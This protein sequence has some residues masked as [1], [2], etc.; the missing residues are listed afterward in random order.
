M[1]LSLSLFSKT[2]V[3][4]SP[5]DEAIHHVSEHAA[6]VLQIHEHRDEGLRVHGSARGLLQIRHVLRAGKEHSQRPHPDERE[7]IAFFS[8]L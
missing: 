7:C 4:R 2:S 5:N 8:H 1:S 6:L 3:I